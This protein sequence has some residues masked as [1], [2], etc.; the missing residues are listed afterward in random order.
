MTKLGL[1]VRLAV[2]LSLGSGAI[3]FYTLP[4]IAQ[5]IGNQEWETQNGEEQPASTPES[6]LEEISTV[7]LND[8]A[9]LAEV[10]AAHEPQR[11]NPIP[12]SE[13]EQPAT[14]IED[15]IAQIEA[16][17]VQI[18]NVRLEE[19]E[20][21]LQII[22]ETAEGELSISETRTVGN[23]L[24]ADISNATIAEE[25][26]QPN[27]IEAIALVSV[28][29]LPGDRVR[30][31]ITGTNAPPVAEVRS[32]GQR[33]VLAVTPGEAIAGT[34]ED[35]IQVVVTGEQEDD[36]Y[37]PDASVGTRTET[38]LRD[39]PASIQVVP[40]QV[41][42]DQ[43]ITRVNEV[44]R[45]VPGVEIGAVSPRS[46]FDDVNIRGFATGF[47]NSSFL[48]NGIQ[49]PRLAAGGINFATIERVEFL[50]GPASVLYGNL[51]PG[52][53][54]NFVTRQPLS[55]PF[56]EIE[57]SVGNFDFYRGE[58]D[59]SGPLNEDGTVLYRFIAG[60]QTTES[61]IDFLFD[62]RFVIAPTLAIE[63]SDN[64]SLNI[65]GEYSRT[66]NSFDQGLPAVGTVLPNPFGE[67]PRDRNL[68]DPDN[69]NV[70]E[71]Y[72][73]GFDFQHRFSDDW[74]IRS[75]FLASLYDQ[76]RDS[77]IS[78][79]LLDDNRSMTRIFTRGNPVYSDDLYNFDTYVT[80]EF[81]TESIQHQLTAGINL[82]WNDSGCVS[83]S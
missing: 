20:A 9:E 41:L 40:R 48:R 80:G 50:R 77:V 57:A 16:S 68:T 36:Y 75:T 60:A 66:E 5:E 69:F 81:F 23:A 2:V 1:M 43:Q 14:T 72:R 79:A 31:A 18:T 59:L 45:N 11:S 19:T 38:L 7:R 78:L 76:D 42:E 3:A 15:W 74:Q 64:T 54:I 21:G 4:A 37:A 30:V 44:L 53:A 47:N 8:S 82:R 34:E 65:W 70:D 29:Q 25:F 52:G 49:D 6:S 32:E 17:L 62:R 61:F 83:P 46:S 39:I 33:F 28:S 63:F 55:E 35:A 27:P 10:Q 13:L 73:L 71:A 22:L 56:Y 26:S 58:L 51:Q 24:I 12:L 67:I